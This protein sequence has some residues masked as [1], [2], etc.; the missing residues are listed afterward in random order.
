MELVLDTKADKRQTVTDASKTDQVN[1]RLK[2]SEVI[3]S[4]ETELKK[5]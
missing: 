2:V 1:D 5:H 3:T 4:V